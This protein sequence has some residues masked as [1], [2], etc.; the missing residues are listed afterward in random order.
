LERLS[1]CYITRV[2][3]DNLENPEITDSYHCSDAD[4]HTELHECLRILRKLE[5]TL[6]AYLPILNGNG[7][8]KGW[9]AQRA[10]RRNGG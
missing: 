5:R 6:D 8:A 2:D 10:V 3:P 4:L 1:R 9:L 7:Q